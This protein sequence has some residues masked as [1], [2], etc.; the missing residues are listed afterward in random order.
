MATISPHF[1]IQTEPVADPAAVVQTANARF[2]LLTERLIRMEHSPSGEF[3]NHASQA[4]WYRKQ[5]VPQFRVT[6][7]AD[8]IEIET[9][10]LRLY[11]RAHREGFTRKTLS[12][13]VKSTGVEW[14]YGE[15]VQ[16]ASSPLFGT[17]RTLD[18]T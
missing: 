10:F 18:E 17:A 13:Q 4:F 7:A 14:R 16:Q 6:Q 11:Y 8:S 3:E 2:T 1:H 9:E 5:P 12:I 15:N